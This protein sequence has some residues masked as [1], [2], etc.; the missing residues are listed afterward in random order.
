MIPSRHW[1]A[2][3]DVYIAPPKAPSHRSFGLTVGGVLLAIGAFGLWRGHVL[4]AEIL[5]GIGAALMLAGL[6]APGSL[7][8]LAKVWGRIGHGLGWVNSRI[9]LTVMFVV[10]LWPIGLLSRLLGKDLLD[11]RRRGGSFWTPYSTRLGTSKHYEN[12]F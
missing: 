8:G 2:L 3:G 6:V 1:K 12:L 5:G 4:R 9:L 10:I 11:S 7:A